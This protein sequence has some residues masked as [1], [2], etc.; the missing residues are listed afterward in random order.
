MCARTDAA[1][2]V[3]AAAQGLR[4]AC[5][6]WLPEGLQQ[7][8]YTPV[9][10]PPMAPHPPLTRSTV[11]RGVDPA[12]TMELFMQLSAIGLALIRDHEG[13]RLDAYLCPAK[14][15]TIGYG[16]A[17]PGVR[18]GLRISEA[19][20]EALLRSD[21]ARFEQGVG[22]IAGRCTQGQFDA[23][24]SFAFN[25]G[26]GALMSS[27]LLKKHKAGDHQAAAAEFARWVNARGRR[28]PGL[29]KRR[30][31]EAALYLS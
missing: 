17:G 12:S 19:E 1:L 4:Y 5:L 31:A 9:C 8:G 13:L 14:V 29:A 16:S 24:V 7:G 25:L 21:V 11:R 20:A 28:L 30:A 2:A 22:R 15:W 18:A 10:L 27:T 6:S 3:R 26:L 23:L